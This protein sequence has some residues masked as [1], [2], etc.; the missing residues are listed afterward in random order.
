MVDKAPAAEDLKET[1]AAADT[2][3][4]APAATT[5][6]APASPDKSGDRVKDT[7][8]KAPAPDADEAEDLG[9]LDDAAAEGEGEG[10]EAAEG[11]APRAGSFLDDDEDAPDGAAEAD[12][13]KAADKKPVTAWRDT[14]L[15]VA[16]QQWLKKANFDKL[17]KDKKEA[18][19][20][21]IA[22]KAEGLRKQLARYGSLEA[23]ALAGM[24]AQATLRAGEAKKKPGPDASAEEVA[25][26]REATGLPTAPKEIDIPKVAGHQ[27]TE[28][29]KPIIDS[30]K[31]AA[32]GADL[33]QASINKLTEWYIA[34]GNDAHRMQMEALASIDKKDKKETKQ[35]LKEEFQD[36][37]DGR[38]ALMDQL[39]G[40]EEVFPD[41]VGEWIKT[42]RT[43]EGRV[44]RNNAAFVKFMTEAA[45]ERYGDGSLITGDAKSAVSTRKA[46]L[47]KLM[48]ENRDE[49]NRIGGD[50]EL[51][52]I[53]AAEE[54][55]A[56]GGRRSR[57]A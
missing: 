1:T 51:I 38:L 43:P 4:K 32:F 22:T 8:A 6:K 19:K 26:W 53:I 20:K 40:D 52:Q 13:K 17:D 16:E 49:Y 7:T 3:D 42:A 2:G 28:R 55:S 37:L 39:L 9:D 46:E 10:D 14:A 50:K 27:W 48:R 57:A 23:A 41:G 35:V 11:D 25:A 5:D 12:D 24:E 31:E 29:D 34:A 44:L 33:P 21:E 45:L 36:E 54:K 47:Q 15:K 18:V 56:G 30:F